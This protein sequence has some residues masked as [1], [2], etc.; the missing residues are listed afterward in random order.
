MSHPQ[1]TIIAAEFEARMNRFYLAERK[2]RPLEPRA[3]TPH[4]CT[5]ECDCPIDLPH[6]QN[7]GSNA[8]D[9]A[10]VTGLAAVSLFWVVVVAAVVRWMD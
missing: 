1:L 7:T 5:Y 9:A 6:P 10:A 3:H 8:L 4:I 2:L